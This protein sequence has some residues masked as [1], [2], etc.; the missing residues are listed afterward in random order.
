MK[1]FQKFSREIFGNFPEIFEGG[2]FPG[3][4]SVFTS[5]ATLGPVLSMTG[6]LRRP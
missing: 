2:C 3:I 1:K 6:F 5:Q 4:F